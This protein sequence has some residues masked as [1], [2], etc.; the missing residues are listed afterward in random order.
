MEIIGAS[1]AVNHQEPVGLHPCGGTLLPHVLTALPSSWGRI[2]RRGSIS[3]RLTRQRSGSRITA[4]IPP[5]GCCSGG[6]RPS[7][8]CDVAFSFPYARE[9][10]LQRMSRMTSRPDQADFFLGRRRH[11][12]YKRTHEFG[13]HPIPFLGASPDS[14][15]LFRI[16]LRNNSIHSS[17]DA[18][19]IK[20]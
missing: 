17:L 12:L 2:G 20:E 11:G 16:I 3:V 13:F 15:G 14:A 4:P 8:S 1:R 18:S 7:R 6:L 5:P 19:E 9:W 10:T